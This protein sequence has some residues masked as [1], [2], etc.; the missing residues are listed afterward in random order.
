MASVNLTIIPY[1]GLS[2]NLSYFC[3]EGQN[4]KVD[5]LKRKEKAKTTFELPVLHIGLGWVF[6]SVFQLIFFPLGVQ[7]ALPVFLQEG[8]G[9]V[10]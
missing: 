5:F 8:L 4:R 10:G 9:T 3:L 7:S 6:L 2:T 1:K